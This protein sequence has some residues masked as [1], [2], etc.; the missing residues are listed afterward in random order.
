MS[1]LIVKNNI[2]KTFQH[3]NSTI[4]TIIRAF[5]CFSKLWPQITGMHRGGKLTRERKCDFLMNSHRLHVSFL[6][7]MLVTIVIASS[8]CCETAVQQQLSCFMFTLATKKRANHRCSTI[9]PIDWFRR[10]F[11]ASIS[12]TIRFN[13][14]NP[15]VFF[16]YPSFPCTLQEQSKRNKVGW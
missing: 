4:R 5:Y 7:K 3:L 13:G 1:G 14:T 10:A 15:A 16:I 2:A 6:T 8:A 11:A 9:R 12:H